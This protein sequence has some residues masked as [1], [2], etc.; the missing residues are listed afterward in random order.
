VSEIGH[1]TIS[2]SEML[3]QRRDQLVI[4]LDHVTATPADQVTVRPVNGRGV[5]H[6]AVP[7][8]SPADQPQL[9]QQIERAVDGSDV[10]SAGARAHLLV[11]LLGGNVTPSVSDSLHDHL[12]LRRETVSL[13][14][15]FLDQRMTRGHRLIANNCNNEYYT[16]KG[17]KR[18]KGLPHR[19]RPLR[20]T[21]VYIQ[22]V[23][24][25]RSNCSSGA[26]FSRI[27]LTM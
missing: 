9:R 3:V 23:N 4:G 1:K 10:H 24:P 18:K 26:S 19:D 27:N 22:P 14:A 20:S 13:L 12:P 5:G 2:L 6:P 8:V 25:N 15:Q 21:L 11:D 16:Q 7:Q 17:K